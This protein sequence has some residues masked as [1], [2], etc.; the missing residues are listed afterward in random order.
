MCLYNFTDTDNP[1]RSSDLGVMNPVCCPC[2]MSVKQ[3]YN[4]WYCCVY[5]VYQQDNTGDR[6][7][8]YDLGVMSPARYLCA[9]PVKWVYFLE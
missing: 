4:N 8:S 6:F 5:N 7:R 2:A 9:T 1:F 3:I